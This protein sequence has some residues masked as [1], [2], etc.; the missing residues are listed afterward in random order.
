MLRDLRGS[1]NESILRTKGTVSNGVFFKAQ[2]HPQHKV[3]GQEY[4]CHV[5]MPGGPGA[6]FIAIHTNLPLAFLKALLD[7]PA[8]GGGFNH[9]GKRSPFRRIGNGVFD[10]SI[11]VLSKK[12]PLLI[13]DRQSVARQIKAKT[14]HFCNDP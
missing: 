2:P 9:F 6:M 14:G 11:V 1:T 8:H 7:R 13:A 10:L 12:E 3:E 5:P 4:E